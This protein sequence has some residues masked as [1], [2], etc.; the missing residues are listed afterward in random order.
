MFLTRRVGGGNPYIQSYGPVYGTS[1]GTTSDDRFKHNEQPITNACDTI[2]QLRGQV[3][4]KTI[5]RYD[6]N[7][8]GAIDEDDTSHKEAGFIAQQ[9]QQIPELEHAVIYN[10]LDDTYNVSYNDVF[11]FNVVATQELITKVRLQA[12]LIASLQ[13]RVDALENAE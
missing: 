10:D 6:E 12:K 5:K 1:F 4:D 3:Y 13:A 2:M 11:T 7:H 9:V 8:Q